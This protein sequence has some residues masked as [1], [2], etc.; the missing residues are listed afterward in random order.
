MNKLEDLKLP[1][2]IPTV[3]LITDRKIVFTNYHK[4]KGEE[5]IKDIEI[6]KAVRASASFPG[7]YSPLEYKEYQ[8]VDGRSF[9]QSSS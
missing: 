8:F 5:Y 6:G 9:R 2:V 1:I 3:D 4:L 7:V